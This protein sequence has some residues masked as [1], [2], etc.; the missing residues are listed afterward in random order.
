MGPGDCTGACSATPGCKAWQYW[1]RGGGLPHSGCF[2]HDGTQGD[3]PSCHKHAIDPELGVVAGGFRA[4]VPPPVQNRSGVT[5][6]EASFDDKSW[7]AVEVPHDFIRSGDGENTD[8]PD[9][10]YSES[11]DMH[12]GHIPRDKSGWYRKHFS[13]PASFGAG[14]ETW[15]HFE[16]V[17]QA[18]DVFLNGEHLLRH[19]SGYLGFD[20]PLHTAQQLNYGAGAENVLALR[21]DSSFGSGHWYEGGGLQRRV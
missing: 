16:G 12:H 5:Y 20:V 14:G 9:Y 8:S 13:L 11:A 18:V 3:E 1:P 4:H 21:V 2:I 17:F 10:P 19:T 6:K 15:L 7:T